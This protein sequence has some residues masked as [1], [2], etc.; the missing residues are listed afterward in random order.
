MLQVWIQRCILG[1]LPDVARLAEDVELDGNESG[2]FIEFVQKR[3]LG[4][5]AI[6]KKLQE[7]VELLPIRPAP[8]AGDEG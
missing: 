6:C 1:K 7:Q 4:F 5:D 8:E 2:V 3:R